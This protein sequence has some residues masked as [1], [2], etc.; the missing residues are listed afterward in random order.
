M[1]KTK[2][3]KN[4]SV[5]FS[6]LRCSL[7]S[8]RSIL[9]PLITLQPDD[10]FNILLHFLKIGIISFR[11]FLSICFFSFWKSCYNYQVR[12]AFNKKKKKNSFSSFLS[13]TVRNFEPFVRIKIM[14]IL[15]LFSCV[16]H[17]E[18][19]LSFVALGAPP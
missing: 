18:I 13:K 11:V 10:Q 16:T 2:K 14:R 1:K 7:H 5:F 6:L 8:K 15:P 9:Q 4:F 3:R 19:S 17:L 12:K